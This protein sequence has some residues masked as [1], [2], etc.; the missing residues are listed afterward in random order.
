MKLSPRRTQIDLAF[1]RCEEVALGKI[2]GCKELE[3]LAFSRT[4]GEFSLGTIMDSLRVRLLPRLLP[5]TEEI[6]EREMGWR[7]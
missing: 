2:G 5:A 1:E 4:L 6:H 7:A 3:Q